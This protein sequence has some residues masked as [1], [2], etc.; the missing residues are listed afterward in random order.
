MKR[1][2]R[3]PGARRGGRFDSSRHTSAAAPNPAFLAALEE[4]RR[5]H[6]SVGSDVRDDAASIAATSSS[7]AGGCS[8]AAPGPGAIPRGYFWDAARGKLFRVPKDA[9]IA[10]PSAAKVK[11]AL[12]RAKSGPRTSAAVAAGPTLSLRAHPPVWYGS[13][14]AGALYSS[15]SAGGCAREAALQ[16]ALT[17]SMAASPVTEWSGPPAVHSPL[18]VTALPAC[19]RSAGVESFSTDGQAWILFVDGQGTLEAG[20]VRRRTGPLSLSAEVE[21]DLTAP[22]A[23]DTAAWRYKTL[24]R[25]PLRGAGD[26]VS[27]ATFFGGAWADGGGLFVATGSLGG[28]GPATLNI[29]YMRPKPG[30]A[31]S[32]DMSAMDSFPV[33]GGVFA[34]DKGSFWS[35]ADLSPSTTGG[36]HGLLAVGQSGKAVIAALSSLEERHSLVGNCGVIK[37][38]SD[39]LAIASAGPQ[40]GCAGS[41]RAA[42]LG[43]RNGT[44]LL[45]DARDSGRDA[46]YRGGAH[47]DPPGI[48]TVFRCGAS[49][50]GLHPLPGSPYVIIADARDEAT[51]VDARMMQRRVRTFAGYTNTAR[52]HGTA[53]SLCGR[54][55]ASVGST[56]TDMQES[57]G[58]DSSACGFCRIWDVN[59]GILLHEA[60][61]PKNVGAGLQCAF[62]ASD[63]PGNSDSRV[64]ASSPPSGSAVGERGPTSAITDISSKEEPEI[65]RTWTDTRPQRLQLVVSCASGIQIIGF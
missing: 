2:V 63:G 26:A 27:C 58:R 37:L 65:H 31:L 35:F 33:K 55:F 34:M 44:V 29:A 23:A 53:L 52:R 61:L 4:Q 22:A 19:G 7:A 5:R 39:P 45:W 24:R 62:L 1:R 15:S 3:S 57:S 36:S 50:A 8:A 12:L 6:A 56:A 17:R 46:Q 51:I 38:P 16:R 30:A 54:F 25:R 40:W 64:R 59:T 21:H 48:P 14:V 42:L 49:V 18:S 13:T 47:P 9:A 60:R 32:D 41:D 20:W 43:L 11:A 28:G 10:P